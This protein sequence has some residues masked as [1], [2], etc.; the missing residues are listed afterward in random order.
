M[1]SESRTCVG[2]PGAWATALSMMPASRGGEVGAADPGVIGGLEGV[3][4]ETEP[5]PVRPGVVVGESDD[6]ARRRLDPG[7]PG[8]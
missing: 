5:V 3:R 4:E 6:L 7:V 2:P 1:S 8:G